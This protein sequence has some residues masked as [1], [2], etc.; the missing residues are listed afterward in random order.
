MPRIFLEN[1]IARN[2]AIDLL[3]KIILTEHKDIE[4]II[5]PALTDGSLIGHLLADKMQVNTKVPL[6]VSVNKREITFRSIDL[7]MLS[8]KKCL[9]VDD[10]ITTGVGLKIVTESLLK[11]IY[12]L[13]VLPHYLFE[14]TKNSMKWQLFIRR[15][16][17]HYKHYLSQPYLYRIK[18]LQIQPRLKK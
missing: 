15:R 1:V 11:T 4:A 12:A 8:S 2:K 16:I 6:N 14:V 18:V 3:A 9:Y 17:S 5:Y 10:V 13:P 7:E